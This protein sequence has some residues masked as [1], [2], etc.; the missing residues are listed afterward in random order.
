MALDRE[1]EHRAAYAAD[2]AGDAV[3]IESGGGSA[4]TVAEL[5]RRADHEREMS[6]TAARLGVLLYDAT[7]VTASLA[8]SQRVGGGQ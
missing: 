7:L 1:A 2:L 5:R 6:K 4:S 8:P 3:R